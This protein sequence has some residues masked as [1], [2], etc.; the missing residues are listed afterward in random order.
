MRRFTA[1]LG[2]CLVVLF[3]TAC[4]HTGSQ[5]PATSDPYTLAVLPWNVVE[6]Y[7]SGGSPFDVTMNTFQDILD[8]SD[9][10]PAFSYYD[11]P[12]RTTTLKDRR[13]IE[14]VWAGRTVMS[15]PDHQLAFQVGEELGVDAVITYA[16]LEK[17]DTDHLF[18]YLFDIPSKHVHSEHGT[19]GRF[20]QD[21][22]LI[23]T[24]MTRSVFR[25]FRKN[26]AIP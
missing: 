23:L 8:K 26:R 6:S 11:L 21:A 16:V 10:V 15:D 19:T 25:K 3:L 2:T 14:N 22:P 20:T 1:F 17:L 5:A 24:S 9:F 13:G 4:G 18:V 7:Y 12:M